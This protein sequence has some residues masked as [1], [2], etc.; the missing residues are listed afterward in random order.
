[1]KQRQ[2]V[3]SLS[4][5]SAQLPTQTHPIG[6]LIPP[7]PVPCT[8]FTNTKLRIEGGGRAVQGEEMFPFVGVN[9]GR[10]TTDKTGIGGWGGGVGGG[11]GRSILITP[12]MS[13]CSKGNF[14]GTGSS[15]KNRGG[16]KVAS[17]LP[18]RKIYFVILKRNHHERSIKPF[19][20]S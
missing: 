2:R 3:V 11:G 18:R 14:Q 20:A 15:N 17:K 5:K 9:P 12:K 7:C 19:S 8:T 6:Q 10:I 1:M 16:S 13:S 4:H